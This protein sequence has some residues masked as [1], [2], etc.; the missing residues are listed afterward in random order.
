M[1]GFVWYDCMGIYILM[2]NKEGIKMTLKIFGSTY[3]PTKEFMN[4][5]EI[6]YAYN[7]MARQLVE[8]FSKDFSTNCPSADSAMDKG[9]SIASKYITKAT[10]MSLDYLAKNKIYTVDADLFIEQVTRNGVL[11]FW[12]DEFRDIKE[13]YDAIVSAANEEV[14]Y[15]EIRK[16]SRGRFIGGGFGVEGAIKGAAQAGAMN[17]ATGMAHSLFN[18]IGNSFTMADM[19][20]KKDRLYESISSR[21]CES[22]FETLRNY[23]WVTMYFMEKEG[24]M[25][26]SYPSNDDLKKANALYNN[27]TAGRIPESE[28][29]NVAVEILKLNPLDE[30][31]YYWMLCEFGDE[32][33]EIEQFASNFQ[34]DLK[35]DKISLVVEPLYEEM[36]KIQT[37]HAYDLDMADLE[38]TL[39]ELRDEIPEAK[40][41]LGVEGR[42]PFEDELD[43]EI[44]RIAEESRT[45][46]GVRFATTKEAADAK[47]DLVLLEKYVASHGVNPDTIKDDISKLKFKTTIVTDRIDE[48]ISK[49]IDDADP[50]KVPAKVQAIFDEEC[51][52]DAEFSTQ[53]MDMPID[54]KIFSESLYIEGISTGYKAISDEAHKKCI[55]NPDETIAFIMKNDALVG[56][57]KYWFIITNCC[58]YSFETKDIEAKNIKKIPFLTI[59]DISV[60]GSGNVSIAKT[61]GSSESFDP[62]FK[63]VGRYNDVVKMEVSDRLTN[64]FRKIIDLLRPLT[65]GRNVDGVVAA[66]DSDLADKVKIL[67]VESWAESFAKIIAKTASPERLKKTV[68]F[69]DGSQEFKMMLSEHAEFWET[70][71][72]NETPYL[73]ISNYNFSH[74]LYRSFVFTSKSVYYIKDSREDSVICPMEQVGKITVKRGKLLETNYIHF[75]GKTEE[76]DLV[77][78]PSDVIGDIADF[79][80]NII[81]TMN[82]EVF[83]IKNLESDLE[84]KFNKAKSINDLKTFLKE[85]ESESADDTI[86]SKYKDLTTAKIEKMEKEEAERKERETRTFGGILFDTVEQR[87]QAEEDNKAIESII[88]GDVKS[89][90]IIKLKEILAEIQAKNF[91][92]E[93]V[94]DYTAKLSKELSKKEAEVEK[95]KS[96]KLSDLNLSSLEK[97]D[98]GISQYYD[99]AEKNG[100]ETTGID[101]KIQKLREAIEESVLSEDG[102]TYS[103]V[104]EAEKARSF[105]QD[106]SARLYSTSIADLDG[107]NA[108]LKEIQ[109]SSVLSKEKY[110]QAIKEKLDEADRLNRT[111]RGIVYSTREEADTARAESKK[112]KQEI[113][114]SSIASWDDVDKYVAIAQ[115]LVTVE[116]KDSYVGYLNLLK[117]VC[118]AQKEL[119]S[120]NVD[121]INLSTPGCY[122]VLVD[123]MV[124]QMKAESLGINVSKFVQWH[125]EIKSKYLTING[126][127]CPNLVTAFDKYIAA[128]EH[129]KL[130]FQYL[131]EKNSTA[132]KGF[133]SK[134]KT[135]VTGVLYAGYEGEYNFVTANGTMDI[136]NNLMEEKGLLV[137][138]AERIDPEVEAFVNDVNNAKA[139]I[140]V[141]DD[142][143][144][145]CVNYN[146]YIQTKTISKKEASDILGIALVENKTDQQEKT[147]ET[148]KPNMA[149][150]PKTDAK[151]DSTKKTVLHSDTYG[152]MTPELHKRMKAKREAQ[153]KQG[154]VNGTLL[155]S[156]GFPYGNSTVVLDVT[157]EKIGNS[158]QTVIDIICA[159]TRKSPDE[160]EKMI[161]KLP[162]VIMKNGD[163]SLGIDMLEDINTVGGKA[164]WKPSM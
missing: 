147:I 79:V 115:S 97:F 33:C 156:Y 123:A 130:Y 67:N 159:Y 16:E 145:G 125:S 19:T 47:E 139:K 6:R 8:E 15:R 48:V 57:K 54:K 69:N 37:A 132:Q 41:D 109:E 13:E 151:R 32:T 142:P 61:N 131:T 119:V 49:L 11:E 124:V 104:D 5:V 94:A 90:G 157:L 134:M 27:I 110:I 1:S 74:N 7:M 12:A 23:Y 96:K 62:E 60:D 71:F 138:R 126:Q 45:V 143:K 17:L 88:G 76:L 18:S 108:L 160:V 155:E 106:F 87:N 82:K 72:A 51:F 117:E 100:V 38:R 68:L 103:T 35:P 9:N 141:A 2:Y 164:H 21:L 84:S 162:A 43:K 55:M 95:E 53:A 56:S 83:K 40:V 42:L 36:S 158:R 120:R 25:K 91:T 46:D 118:D 92:K 137:K 111:V 101:E 113:N 150:E 98:E 29:K 34:I 86:V 26:Y 153:L 50:S 163:G 44:E 128:V 154:I 78:V 140:D 22:L 64:T 89:L 161:A 146:G 14:A 80:N 148:A 31:F 3:T 63:G 66:P 93:I 30:D 24:V 122:T 121:Y 114:L 73:V 39:I 152:D 75:N 102:E 85:L 65:N 135:G 144:V 10:E 129:A 77:S 112:M 149:T 99:W 133:L 81:C 70:K 59:S 28:I 52:F 127:L 58:V 107:L 4:Y 136:P 105:L 116:L 20:K